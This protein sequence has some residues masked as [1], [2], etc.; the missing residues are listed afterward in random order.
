[1]YKTSYVSFSNIVSRP[2]LSCIQRLLSISCAIVSEKRDLFVLGT[3]M[4]IDFR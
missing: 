1:M 3:G 4:R 2:L